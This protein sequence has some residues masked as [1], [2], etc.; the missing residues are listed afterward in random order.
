MTKP[1]PSRATKESLPREMLELCN[2]VGRLD[3][4]HREEL[5]PLCERVGHLLLLQ[6]RLL[7]IAQ[8]AVDQLQLDAKYLTFDLEVTRRERDEFRQELESEE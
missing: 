2:Q 6:N 7:R 1:L 4:A 8:D 5:S 3:P